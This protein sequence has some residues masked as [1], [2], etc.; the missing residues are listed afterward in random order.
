MNN[1]RDVGWDMTD[2]PILENCTFCRRGNCCSSSALRKGRLPQPSPAWGMAVS[3]EDQADE[4]QVCGAVLCYLPCSRACAW[5]LLWNTDLADSAGKGEKGHVSLWHLTGLDH[6]FYAVICYCLVNIHLKTYYAALYVGVSQ[7]W[8]PY[9]W[10][11][12]LIGPP[13]DQIRATS[14][15]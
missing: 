12:P 5:E 13:V 1:P 10:P 3:P 9:K 14:F 15:C 7:A 11:F 8:F 6:H 2:P 4:A